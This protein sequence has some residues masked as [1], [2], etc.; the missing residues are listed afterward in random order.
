MAAIPEELVERL[1]N[2]TT[3]PS[4]PQVA[5]KVIGLAQDPESDLRAIADT[6]SGDPAIAAKI[7]K[8]ASLWLSC[9]Q[10]IR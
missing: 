5:L 8:I 10:I 3:F 4:P 2:C 6:C 7:M 9:L 1:Q